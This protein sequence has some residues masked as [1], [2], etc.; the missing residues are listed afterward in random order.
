MDKSLQAL[1]STLKEIIHRLKPY[2]N[3]L[4][5]TIV[6]GKL[7]QG[8]SALLSQTKLEKISVEKVKIDIYYNNHGILL[9]LNETWLNESSQLLQ[10]TLKQINRCH[11]HIHITALLLCIDVHELFSTDP[12]ELNQQCKGHALLLERFGVAL[13]YIVDVAVFITKLDKLA[14]FCDFFEHEHQADL[15]KPLGFSLQGHP[16]QKKWMETYHNEFN[17]FID[18]LNQKVI[19]KLHLARSSIKRNHIREFPLQLNTL[20]WPLQRLMQLLASPKFTFQGIYFTSAEQGGVSLDRINKKIQH[21]YALAT[22][23][24][25]PQSINYRPYFIEG[26]ILN[27]QGQTPCPLPKVTPWK[28]FVISGISSVA[29][30]SFAFIFYGYFTTNRLLD[31]VSKELLSYDTLTGKSSQPAK[32]L[33]HLTKAC[34]TLDKIKTS[35]VLQPSLQQ[36]KTAIQYDTQQH[37][38]NIFIPQQLALLEKALTSNTESHAARYQALKIYLMLG[39]AKHYDEQSVVNWF[40][41]AWQQEKTGLDLKENKVLLKKALVQEHQRLKINQT[42]VTDVRNILNALPAHYL[43]YSLAKSLFPQEKVTLNFPGFALAYQDLP[44]YFT[45]DGF[46]HIMADIPHYT[47]QLQAEQWVLGRTDLDQLP[48]ILKQAYSYDYG[49]WWKNM[50]QKTTLQHAQ[51]YQQAGNLAKTLY[52]SRALPKL[53]ALIQNNTSP[54]LTAKQPLFNQAVAS[55]FTQLSLISDRLIQD[56]HHNLG[57][58]EKYLSTLAL[59][60]DGGKTAFMLTKAR[61]NEDQINNPL[62][63]L[64]TYAQQFPEPVAAWVEQLANESWMN[65]MMNSRDYINNQWQQTVFNAYQTRI[66]NR[67]PFNVNQETEISLADFDHF[68]AKYGTLNQFFK[69]YLSPFLDTSQPDWQLKSSHGYVLPVAQDTIKQL[70]LAN[71]ITNMFFPDESH[72]SHIEFSLQKLNLDPVVARLSLS[73]GDIRLTDTQQTESLTQFHWPTSNANLNLKSIDG[74]HYELAEHGDWAIFKL[75]QKVN[76]LIDEQDSTSLQILLEINGNSG[77][78]L[79][80]SENKVNPFIPGILN[81]FVLPEVV[82]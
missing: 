10:Y 82:V 28:R 29:V 20:A 79:L 23:D 60:N 35:H 36:L 30:C 31:N 4:S 15:L 74:H 69:D 55:Q 80:K 41:H 81:G 63:Q 78:Y 61:F 48:E 64:F 1:C 17:E 66:A 71:I 5:L 3:P 52:Q 76:V 53:M 37:L 14:G 22:Q 38:R 13:G 44:V 7:T 50:M 9:N 45:K 40:E 32:A 2:E 19:H 77:R 46:S 49:V 58:L 25:F 43:L 11:K 62:N 67:F 42:L 72:H 16:G 75:L 27:L 33:Y 26:A 70:I 8:T 24:S 18:D 47:A 57:E 21:E 51:N 12:D 68:F 56:F 34:A 73:I 6:T 54:D 65:L 39:N 59:V